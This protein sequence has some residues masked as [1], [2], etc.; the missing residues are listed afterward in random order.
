VEDI[1]IAGEAL[2]DPHGIVLREFA[3]RIAV[4]DEVL[5]WA[6]RACGHGH[7]ALSA[8]EKFLLDDL[9]G[10]RLPARHLPHHLRGGKAHVPFDE[11]FHEIAKK[12]LDD[13]AKRA[14]R[15]LDDPPFDRFV[16]PCQGGEDAG[17]VGDEA[18]LGFLRL[19]PRD[20][21]G[22][23]GDL[24]HADDLLDELV[25]D[26]VRGLV[27]GAHGRAALL[28]PPILAECSDVAQVAP[29]AECADKFRPGRA[30]VLQVV[31]H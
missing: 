28:A 24:G 31:G 18:F 1:R 26:K 10:D 14:R 12:R 27:V 2:A 3:G 9:L 21:T 20:G 22:G 23:D 5:E 25:R 6:H 16:R 29:S 17:H 7:P 19:F 11:R 15:G 4:A 13:K 30:V 8:A